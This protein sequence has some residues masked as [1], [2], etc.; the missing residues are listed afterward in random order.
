MRRIT[1]FVVG[2][3]S[4]RVIF[5][6]D[7]DNFNTL[8][9]KASERLGIT[10]RSV[11]TPDGKP[12][13]TLEGLGATTILYF[14]SEGQAREEKREETR[15]E[16][17]KRLQEE[18]I[19]LFEAAKARAPVSPAPQA[20]ASPIPAQTWENEVAKIKEL[21]P[22]L[23]DADILSAIKRFH[24]NTERALEALLNGT[25]S[26][27][28]PAE[29]AE[30]APRAE[31]A[32]SVFAEPAVKHSPQVETI[33]AMLPHLALERIEAALKR[34]AN[35][36][37]AVAHLLG[38]AEE[39][40]EQ[41]QAQLDG[42]SDE[43][44]SDEGSD[45]D[46]HDDSH[47]DSPETKKK[48]DF[49]EQDVTQLDWFKQALEQQ[50]AYEKLMKLKADE[51]PQENLRRSG[52]VMNEFYERERKRLEEQEEIDRRVAM[53]LATHFRGNIDVQEEQRKKQMEEDERLAR[54]LVERETHEQQQT[55]KTINNDL[56]LAKKL[57][58]EYSLESQRKS[59]AEQTK[60]D[61]QIA[62]RL[63]L[64]QKNNESRARE[65]AKKD[66]ELARQLA[67][68]NDLRD[69]G[70]IDQR[71][72]EL[73][74]AEMA[75][76]LQAEEDRRIQL[77]REREMERLRR[78]A[79]AERIRHEAA[80]AQRLRQIDYAYYNHYGSFDPNLYWPNSWS[81]VAS[82]FTGANCYLTHMEQAT[83]DPAVW[84]R[85]QS[86]WRSYRNPIVVLTFHGTPAHNIP[87]ILRQGLRIPNQGP[88]PIAVAHGS[89]YGVGIYVATTPSTSL[90]Y[91][92]G[93]NRML[94]CATLVSADRGVTS[95]NGDVIVV[96]NQSHVVPCYIAHFSRN[97][98][99]PA[100]IPKPV[101]KNRFRFKSKN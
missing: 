81:M 2:Q 13:A 97:N 44:Y 14:S 17:L 3:A 45:D 37:E 32:R 62:L 57:A 54:L 58:S 68:Q 26:P 22:H 7:G 5:L 16:R 29:P 24:G 33:R 70:L 72:A 65:N 51:Q 63:A 55:S 9:Q 101:R 49:L 12:L 42:E 59:L 1:A 84:N 40:R 10:A 94:V 18:Q 88:N 38:D 36:E 56:E 75:R 64:E 20:P 25:A 66:E 60:N 79:E 21:L 82:A 23:L 4:G 41:H 74:D 67:R 92:T 89:A 77:E 35:V 73:N 98:E 15:E 96:F 53:E 46:S 95:R 76:R 78:D 43:E 31:L 61:A 71:I 52:E 91:V 87:S 80:E 48:D 28:E 6:E 100:H 99:R 83:V 85:F 27:A 34:F 69:Y 11:M 93:G 50:Q 47:D 39:K 8:L 30:P 19:R 86:A 90:S